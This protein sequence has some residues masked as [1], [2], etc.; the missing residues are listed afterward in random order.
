MTRTVCAGW[1]SV[2][3]ILVLNFTMVN[4]ASLG[5][6]TVGLLCIF[7][8]KFEGVC[9]GGCNCCEGRCKGDC[10]EE[11]EGMCEEGLSSSNLLCNL[12]SFA[13]IPSHP[14]HP[15]SLTPSHFSG[16]RKKPTV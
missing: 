4:A 7:P 5:F 13:Q 3:S 1:E 16:M 14:L 15:P 2:D 11:C 6:W 8:E 10:E 9:E 12:L